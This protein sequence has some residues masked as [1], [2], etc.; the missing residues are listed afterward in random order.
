V[1]ASIQR[2]RFRRVVRDL[3]LGEGE[4]VSVDVPLPDPTPIGGRIT[5][6][7]DIPAA[8]RPVSI[9]IDLDSSDRIADGRFTIRAVHPIDGVARFFFGPTEQYVDVTANVETRAD[10]TLAVAYPVN[11]VELFVLEANVPDATHVYATVIRPPCPDTF[12]PGDDLRNGHRVGADP[13]GT[14]SI[15]SR[16]GQ[17]VRGWVNESSRSGVPHILAWFSSDVPPGTIVPDGRYVEVDNAADGTAATVVMVPRKVSDW[18]PPR[19]PLF[20]VFAGISRHLW[21]PAGAEFLDVEFPG[22]P[23][24][25]VPAA[26][27]GA[28]WTI[29]PR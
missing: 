3:T 8:L 22:R 9:A 21:L 11:D 4:S 20:K 7:N 29:A 13:H 15:L 10:G 1:I 19:I 2:S 28:Q 12:E 27:I 18:Q 16:R 14:M 5:N 25:R 26:S 17:S 23:R 24:D 6:W